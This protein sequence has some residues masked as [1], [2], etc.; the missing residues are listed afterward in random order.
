MIQ[1]YFVDYV[2]LISCYRFLVDFRFYGLAISI[3]A[4]ALRQ[5]FSFSHYSA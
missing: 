2:K 3:N 5:T 4:A 1:L